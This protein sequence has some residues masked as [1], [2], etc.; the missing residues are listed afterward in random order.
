MV[1]SDVL[2]SDFSSNTFE[3]AY[4]DKPTIYYVPDKKYVKTNMR[5]YDITAAK[6]YE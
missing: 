3:F 4:M 6:H 5:Q 2:V 1:E